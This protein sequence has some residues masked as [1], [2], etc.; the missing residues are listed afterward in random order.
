[1]PDAL[2]VPDAPDLV[3][4]MDFMAD[5][6]GEGRPFWLL[7]VFNREG[8]GIEVDFSLLTERAIRSLDRVIEWRGKPG[9]IRV[10]NGP[11]YNGTELLAWAAKH[12]ISTCS[13]QPGHPQQTA[14]IE[15]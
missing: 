10:V 8:L 2:G 1:M 12:K 9:R 6:L 3:W 14:H 4:S 15:R 11:K 5:K 13:I 7:N